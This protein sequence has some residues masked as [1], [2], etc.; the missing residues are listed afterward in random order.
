MDTTTALA[1]VIPEQFHEKI[2]TI[3]KEHDKAYPRWM[4]HIN[5]LFPFLPKNRFEEIHNRLEQKLKLIGKFTINLIDV[6]YFKKKDNGTMHLIP[7]DCEE[8]R[9][10]F[11]VIKK[12]IPETSNKHGYTPHMTIGQFKLDIIE[13]KQNQYREWLG[14]GINFEVDRV[15]MLSRSKSDPFIIDTI[16]CLT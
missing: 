13:E 3:R 2:N 9:E 11:D 14:Y 16:I 15:C 1:I 6:G 7:E 4:P 8:L 10:L 5:I 12:E